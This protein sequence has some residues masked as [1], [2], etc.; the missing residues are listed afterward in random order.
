MIQDF[1]N[2]LSKED[3]RYLIFWNVNFSINRNGRVKL[4][5]SIYNDYS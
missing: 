4:N 5:S 1:K 2:I 3:F